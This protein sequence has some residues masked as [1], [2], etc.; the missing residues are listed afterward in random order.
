VI[1]WREIPR[2]DLA[3]WN[4]RLLQE[5]AASIRQFPLFNEGLRGSGALW[6]TIPGRYAGLIA[7]G[8]RWTTV[9]RYL[10]HRSASGATTFVT[11]V[12]IGVPGLRFGC[13]LDGPIALEGAEIDPSLVGELLVWARHNHYVALRLT[14]SD[15]AFLESLSAVGPSARVNGVPFYPYPESEL[16]VA[17]SSDDAA[18][19][20]SFQPVARRNIRQAR[21][22]Q[23]ILTVDDDPHAMDKAWPAF[24][25]RSAHKGISY[26]N[27]ETYK[28][29]MREA[30]PHG[31][32]HLHTAWR[33]ERPIAAI[34]VLRDRTTAHYFLG[35]IDTDALGDLPSPA[36]LLHWSAIKH[37]RDM[38]ASWYNLGT[39]S[40]PV[41]TF[42]AKFRPVE[43][44]RPTPLTF[45]VNSR[46]YGL[47][48]RM[49][50][51][52]ARI[53]T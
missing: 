42:K 1:G 19:L 6:V 44:Q 8:R 48:Q 25:S 37:A 40:G 22:A 34:L 53:V 9:P 47:W 24:Q 10:Q 11:I 5:R 2:A 21:D 28:R 35:T 46:I 30:Q 36:V 45:R 33:D 31:T 4:H 12:T 29:M 16:Y 13:V 38:G 27:L 50:P 18:M 49:L 51:A 14:H 17:L 32:A 39:R 26:R 3:A 20:S 52:I 43:H 7:L 23:F 15:E 41:Y